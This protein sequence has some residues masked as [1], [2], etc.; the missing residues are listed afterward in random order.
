MSLLQVIPPTI[1]LLYH[2]IGDLSI[3][4][5]SACIWLHDHHYDIYMITYS[6]LWY[7]YMITYSSLWYIYDYILIIAQ[8][9]Y[10]YILIAVINM[11]TYSSL[12][13][14]WLVYYILN[15]HHCSIYMITCS[16]LFCINNYI[17]I[18]VIYMIT[19]SSLFYM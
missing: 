11:I 6:S 19:Y 13:Y 2:T 10:D 17:L 14:I 3:N 12:W 15:T 16:S 9:V 1:W 18:T 4:H 5:C 8:Y 7:M